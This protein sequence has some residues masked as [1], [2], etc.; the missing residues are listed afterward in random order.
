MTIIRSPRVCPRNT[1]QR[2]TLSNMFTNQRGNTMR[3]RLFRYAV[4]AMIAPIAYVIALL[5]DSG[6]LHFL[7]HYYFGG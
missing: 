6:H 3:D 7:R 2:D 1:L 5:W 4:I